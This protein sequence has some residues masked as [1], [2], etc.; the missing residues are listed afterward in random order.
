MPSFVRPLSPSV[1]VITR[2]ER[3]KGS[4]RDLIGGEGWAI[5]PSP[6]GRC[7]PAKRRASIR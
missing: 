5:Y 3:V 4:G 7:F 2:D 1:G 6:I